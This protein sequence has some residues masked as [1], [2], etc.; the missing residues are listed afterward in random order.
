MWPGV[1]TVGERR[2]RWCRV[3]GESESLR[4]DLELLE[5]VLGYNSGDLRRHASDKVCVVDREAPTSSPDRPED[6]LG[7]KRTDASKIDHLGGD[8]TTVQEDS[9]GLTFEGHVRDP[10]EGDVDTRSDHACLIEGDSIV[11][12]RYMAADVI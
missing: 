4:R 11:D 7:V 12:L 1:V 8:P 9:G 5:C 10:D 6:R 3:I 2:A